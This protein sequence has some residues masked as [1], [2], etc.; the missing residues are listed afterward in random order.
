MK[1]IMNEYTSGDIM[2]IIREWSHETQKEFGKRIGKSEATVYQYE[3]DK[4]NYTMEMFLHILKEY[5]IS[6]TIEK[7][8]ERPSRN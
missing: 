5:N 7:N 3:A 1:L 6:I 8:P 2:R 4:V